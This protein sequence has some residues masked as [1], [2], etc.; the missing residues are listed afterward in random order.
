MEAI[1]ELTLLVSEMASFT[2]RLTKQLEKEIEDTQKL[3]C[4]LREVN[5]SNEN[6]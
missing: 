6:K 3:A 2:E 5:E 4:F 1:E